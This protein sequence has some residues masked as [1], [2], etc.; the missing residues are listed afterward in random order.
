MITVVSGLPRSGTSLMMQMLEAGGLEPLTDNARKADEGNPKGYFEFERAKK[1]KEDTSWLVQAE[2]KVVKLISMLLLDLPLDRPYK[3]LFMTRD[4]SEILRSQSVML[5]RMGNAGQ[6]PSD[7]MM[8]K[9][10]ENHLQ[11]VRRWLAEHNSLDVIDVNYNDMIKNPAPL[12]ARIARFLDN[13]VDPGKML[14]IVD[15]TLY[16]QQKQ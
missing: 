1:L 11:K 10:Y 13:K 16:R 2:G 5:E 3:I 8:R 4:M 6:G 15:P 7:D 12:A 9:H 14:S